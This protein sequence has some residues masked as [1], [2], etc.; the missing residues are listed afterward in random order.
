M[1][2]TAQSAAADAM[3]GRKQFSP[4]QTRSKKAN[5]IPFTHVART[6]RL[7][8]CAL[9]TVRP[10]DYSVMAMTTAG[11]DSAALEAAVLL[12]HASAL[13]ARAGGRALASWRVTWPQAL[14]LLALAEQ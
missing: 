4:A 8:T 6:I 14:S 3:T 1:N 7:C 9:P 13:L 5:I 2:L 11:G 12:S 10:T